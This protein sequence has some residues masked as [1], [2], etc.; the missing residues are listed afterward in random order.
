MHEEMCYEMPMDLTE[1]DKKL[2]EL[3]P[4][5]DYLIMDFKHF[6]DSALKKFTGL[7]GIDIKRNFE[8]NCILGRQQHIRIP[9]INGINTDNPEGFVQYFMK[10]D[11]SNTVFEFLRYHEYGKKKWQTEYKVK[12]GFV[13]EQTVK[14]FKKTFEEHNLKVIGA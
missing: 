3:L 5:I 12:N 14:S 8:N 1:I 2:Q 9:L 13:D 6:D 4:Y 10:H 7:Y 11:T